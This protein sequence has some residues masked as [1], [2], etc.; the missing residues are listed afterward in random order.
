MTDLTPDRPPSAGPRPLGPT[1]PSRTAQRVH[2]AAVI[3]VGLL[4]LI[5]YRA[6]MTLCPI[7]PLPAFLGLLAGFWV[8]V[9]DVAAS[10][11]RGREVRTLS[12]MIVSL[13][14]GVTI[15]AIALAPFTP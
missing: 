10:S 4:A 3:S 7:L 13:G 15:A 5:F 14:G 1:G 12:F 9:A 11:I 2:A 8:A 6:I